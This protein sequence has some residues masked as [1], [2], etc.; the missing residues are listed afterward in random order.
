MEKIILSAFACNPYL[1]SEA[2]YGWNWAIG[3]VNEG[4]EVHCL[5][6]KKNRKS[7]EQHPSIDHLHFHYISLSFGLERLYSLSQAT[8]YLY[9]ILWQWMAYRKAKQLSRVYPFKL[10]HHV[11]WGSIQQ[12]SFLYKLKIPFIFG[13]AGG[14]QKAPEKFKDYFL[15]HWSAE[16]KREKVSKL[17]VRF[18]PACK[19]MLRK[20]S[21]VLV[22]NKDTYQLAQHAGAKNV[23]STLDTAL[24]E[25][26][27]QQGLISHRPETG[28]IKLLW[29]GRFLPRKGLLLVLEV[30]NALKTH[31]GIT[32]T[33][34]GDGEMR[35]AVKAKYNEFQIQETVSFTGLVPYEE[36]NK[37]Y[38]THDAF[39]FTS[40]RESGGVQLVE[41]MAYSLPVITLDLHGSAEII[42]EQTGIKIPVEE[43]LQV[44][45]DLAKAI[46]DLANDPVRYQAMSLAAFRF[47]SEQTWD[48]KIKD[49]VEK[50]Y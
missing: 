38:A 39:F 28:Q 43:P 7:I 21:A 16:E 22:S 8:M 34:V 10:A 5:T 23:Y 20:A 49:I 33:I 46:L 29:V 47:A 44:I 48:K 32:L 30:M 40:L 4:Y 36:V 19:K 12:G 35:E 3:L 9:Y 6:S 50:Y 25:R 2:G 27:F 26:F 18:N 24:P 14:G 45:T 42:T 37:Y 31:P 1:G 17:L 15:N 41:A 13:P 11:T